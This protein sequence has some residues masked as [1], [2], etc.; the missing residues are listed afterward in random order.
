M[1]TEKFDRLLK[2]VLAVTFIFA[3]GQL[4]FNAVTLDSWLDEGNYLMKGYW[5]ITG[6]IPPYSE[7]DRT[8]YMPIFFYLVGGLQKLFGTGYA[9]GR[10]M[11]V[12]FGAGC[13]IL[14]YLTGIKIGR[15][16]LAG[17]AALVLLAGHNVTLTYFATA[18]PYSVV[19]FLSL[20]L[21]F[22]LLYLDNRRMA[23]ALSGVILW[24][25]VFIRPNMLPVALIITGW[26]VLIEPRRKLELLALAFLA[27]CLVSIPTMIWFGTGLLDVIL[28]VPGISHLN[29]ILGGEP[30]L[31]TEVIPLTASPM[32]P[33][34]RP[35]EVLVYFV[36][37]F[38]E[39][40]AVVS[41]ITLWLLGIR[42]I[43]AWRNF[44]DFTIKPMD[45]LLVYFWVTT[46]LHFMLSL[47]YCVNCI[48]PYTSYFLPVGVLAIA[49]LMDET[50]GLIKRP[51]GEFALLGLVIAGAFWLQLFPSFPT[52]LRP[53]KNL[54]RELAVHYSEQLRPL[55]KKGERLAVIDQSAAPAQAVWLAGGVVEPRT[56]YMP[57]SFREPRAKPG[58]PDY[59]KAEGLLWRA[60][61]WDD[62]TMGR[63]I[64]ND[65]QTVLI[66]KRQKYRDPLSRVVRDGLPFGDLLKKYYTLAAMINTG[67]QKLMLYRRKE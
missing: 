51:G 13:F 18:T 36:R 56:I 54:V 37:F 22:V 46:V 25:L 49:G 7:V 66:N 26:A 41:F 27:F 11:A 45:L 14:V 23:F 62:A 29:S 61:F 53:Q 28:T 57:I 38:L 10:S 64:A 43:R 44:G 24:A 59:S 65:Y 5:Y 60:G 12:L 16:R 67:N 50:R 63:A 35:Y 47:S 8:G 42:F 55:I 40:Y 48:I 6:Q 21:I 3:A 58:Q 31:I 52:L 20:L 9:A 2:A 17:V 39:P 32:D 33:V 30:P 4:T 15:S 1:R 19:S 34:V